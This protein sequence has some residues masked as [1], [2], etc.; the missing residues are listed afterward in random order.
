VPEA[1]RL[2]VDFAFRE[3][4]MHRVFVDI[5]PRNTASVR[6]AEKLG[7]RREAWLVENVW[8]KGEWCDSVIYA[9][10]EREWLSATR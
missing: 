1:A 2:V 6:I 8:S 5:D 4:K 9:L 10:L 3:L 7:M